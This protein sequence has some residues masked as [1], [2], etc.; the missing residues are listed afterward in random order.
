MRSL[1]S[2]TTVLAASAAALA[3]AGAASAADPAV[4]TS[5]GTGGVA[6]VT[7]NGGYDALAG[8]DAYRLPDDRI[9]TAGIEFQY[10]LAVTRHLS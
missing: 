7:L 2:I 9:V 8:G 10:G 5:F 4:D 1:R 3:P 6:T